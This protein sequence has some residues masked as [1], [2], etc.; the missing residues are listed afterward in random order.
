MARQPCFP[1]E[2]STAKRDTGVQSLGQCRAQRFQSEKVDKSST[3]IVLVARNRQRHQ[4]SQPLPVIEDFSGPA[5]LGT[6]AGLEQ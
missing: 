3:H 2:L 1:F 6:D 5:S 4:A